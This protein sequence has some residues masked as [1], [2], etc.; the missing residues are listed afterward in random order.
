MFTELTIYD[1]NNKCYSMHFDM[2]E[3]WKFCKVH[4]LCLSLSTNKHSVVQY[5]SDDY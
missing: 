3:V 4:V 1:F 2:Y 5:I